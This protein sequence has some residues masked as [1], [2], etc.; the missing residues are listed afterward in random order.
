LIESIQDAQKQRCNSDKESRPDR[1]TTKSSDR[2][3]VNDRRTTCS[4]L[5]GKLPDTVRRRPFVN[6]ENTQAIEE[7]LLRNACEIQVLGKRRSFRVRLFPLIDEGKRNSLGAHIRTTIPFH[8]GISAQAI[9]LE[10]V[11]RSNGRFA[12]SMVR[13]IIS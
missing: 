2:F 12:C 5:A 9:D 4:L 3:A 13:I 1:F 6:W 10:W 11:K 7:K 8:P